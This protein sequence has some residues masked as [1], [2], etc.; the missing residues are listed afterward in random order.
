MSS[1]EQSTRDDRNTVDAS[2]QSTDDHQQDEASRTRGP[3]VTI[4]LVGVAVVVVIA[5]GFAITIAAGRVPEDRG[6]DHPIATET[7]SLLGPPGDNG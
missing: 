2:D 5:V 4:I 6:R 1:H 7:S 3:L